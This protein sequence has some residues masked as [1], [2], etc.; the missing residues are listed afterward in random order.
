MSVYHFWSQTCP[1][2]QRLK[3]VF[4]D[5]RDDYPAVSWTSVDIRNDPQKLAAQFGI[6]SVPAMVS[7]SLDGTIRKHS[8]SDAIGYFKLMKETKN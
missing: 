7:V 4:Q 3:P 8:G 6:T 5:L 1:P 2:C